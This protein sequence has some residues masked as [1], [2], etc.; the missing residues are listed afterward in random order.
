MIVIFDTALLLIGIIVAIPSTVLFMETLAAIVSRP[1]SKSRAVKSTH[2]P[3]AVLV[4]AHNEG[5][6]I[7]A[8]LDSISPQ[9]NHSDMLVVIADNCTDD[10]AKIA[11]SHGAEIVVRNDMSQQGKGFALAC[12]LA[13]LQPRQPRVVIIIDAD[14]RVEVGSIQKL[15]ETCVASHRPVQALNLMKSPTGEE[16]RFAVAEFAWIVRNKVRPMGLANLGM[17]CQLMGTGMAFPWAIIRTANLASSNVVEDLEL[18]IELARKGFPPLFSV[19][20]L[21]ESHFPMTEEGA[22]KQRQRWEQGSLAMLINNGLRTIVEAIRNR[23]VNLFVMGFDMMVPPLAL[24]AAALIL[25]SSITMAS[26][27]LGASG[28]LSFAIVILSNFLFAAAL[29]ISWLGFGR[30]ALPLG[31][32]RS[33][34][35]YLFAK[36]KIYRGF[37]SRGP[38]QWI[39]SDRTRDK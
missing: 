18:G 35:P 17:P 19:E 12:G 14:C 36:L 1:A 10:T 39:R 26:Y 34:A 15:A 23:N 21:V 27:L 32:L 33:L 30:I 2:L 29:L 8:T 7:G 9:L 25:V 4:P 22:L 28:V 31:Q 24:H 38:K 20:A 16:V 6:G 37:R 3:I 13:W 11:S 5:N